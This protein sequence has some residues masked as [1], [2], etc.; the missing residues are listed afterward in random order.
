M[1]FGSDSNS[2]LGNKKYEQKRVAY[3][4]S[5]FSVANDVARENESWTIHEFRARQRD[6]CNKLKNIL[7]RFHDSI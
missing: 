5:R 3:Q 6:V 2:R 7:L 4:D 1:I